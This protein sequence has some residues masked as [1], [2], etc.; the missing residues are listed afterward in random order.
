MLFY[1]NFFLLKIFR[2]TYQY[3]DNIF[4][5]AD[6][7]C[8]EINTDDVYKDFMDIK[9]LLVTSNYVE[10]HPLFSGVNKK[11]PGKMKD[12]LAGTFYSMLTKQTCYMLLLLLFYFNYFSPVIY[13]SV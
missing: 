3:F 12:E 10:G 4:V 7:L 11:V 13:I 5:V 8:Y 2:V 1:Y 9:D 6:S